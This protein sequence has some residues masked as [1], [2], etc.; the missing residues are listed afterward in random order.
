M[1]KELPDQE[2]DLFISN[3]DMNDI[4][5]IIKSLDN[6]VVLIDGVTE[7]GKHEIK[8]K[9]ADFLAFC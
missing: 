3:G 1:E 5:Q 8:N 7:T 2:K 9:E 4:I 6:W